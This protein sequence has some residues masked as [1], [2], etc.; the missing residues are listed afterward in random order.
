[1]RKLLN[2]RS[3]LD[4]S[5]INIAGGVYGKDMDPMEFSNLSSASADTIQLSLV[6]PINNIEGPI[7]QVCDI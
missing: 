7:G 6:F 5:S 2:T 3:G 4:F 1:M